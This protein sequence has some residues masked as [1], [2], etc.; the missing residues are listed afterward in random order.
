MWLGFVLREQNAK[1]ISK[2][3]QAVV[4][5]GARARQKVGGQ[6]VKAEASKDDTSVVVLEGRLEDG[7]HGDAD[8]GQRQDDKQCVGGLGEGGRAEQAETGANQESGRLQ[9][10]TGPVSLGK[11]GADVEADAVDETDDIHGGVERLGE[12]EQDA[13]GTAK[14]GTKGPRDEVVRAAA[15]DLAI[16]GNGRQR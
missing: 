14:L 2:R 10:V 15:F 16:G 3:G 7:R 1:E 12:E 4:F 11:A 8:D 13:N 6:G 9:A 5:A